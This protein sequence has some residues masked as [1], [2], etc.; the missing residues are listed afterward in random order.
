[1]PFSVARL[2][3]EDLADIYRFGAEQFG[4]A[5]ADRYYGDLLIA[6]ARLA[7]SLSLAPTSEAGTVPA[8]TDSM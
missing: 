5:A 8:F 3:A 2:A 7:D 1:M 4:L 6:F